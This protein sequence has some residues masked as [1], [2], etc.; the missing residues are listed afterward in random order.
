MDTTGAAPR[1]DSWMGRATGAPSLNRRSLLRIGA[2]AGSGLSLAGVERAEAGAS[3]GK[4]KIR[5]FILIFYYGGS[6]RPCTWDLK[7]AAPAEIRG[8]FRPIPPSA[9]G[10]RVSEHL[11]C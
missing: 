2:L 9:P 11:P 5:S 1:G 4:A 10:V 8:E 6:A 3:A 7:P